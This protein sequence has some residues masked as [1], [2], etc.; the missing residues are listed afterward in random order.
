[1]TYNHTQIGYLM[2]IVLLVVALLFFSILMQANFDL[3]FFVF[4]LFILVLI[5]SFTFLN[6]KIDEKYLRIKFGYGIFKKRFAI[7]EIVSVKAVKNHWYYGWGDQ[8]MVLAS[9]GDF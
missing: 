6:V 5:S 2:I 4:M 3:K 8:I 7:R 9:H 1:M